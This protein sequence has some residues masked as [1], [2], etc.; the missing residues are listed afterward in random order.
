MV[1]TRSKSRSLAADLRLR[2]RLLRRSCAK[3]TE[4]AADQAHHTS[5]ST[6]TLVASSGAPTSAGS[7]SSSSGTATPASPQELVAVSDDDSDF[8]SESSDDSGSDESDFQEPPTR[9]YFVIDS[10]RPGADICSSAGTSI[11]FWQIQG[12]KEEDP[13]IDAPPEGDLDYFHRPELFLH[14]P[15][16]KSAWKSLPGPPEMQMV[17][18]PPNL[19]IRLLPFQREGFRGGVLADEM[20]M[21]KTLQTIGLMLVNRGKPTLVICPTVALMQWKSEI[22]A[23]YRRPKL[24]DENGDLNPSEL[25][26][27]DVVLTTYAVVE[28]SF[29]RER[30]GFRRHG[31]LLHED[32][33]LHK[34]HNIKDRSSNS[35]QQ[36]LQPVLTHYM[37]HFCYWNYHIMNPIQK[38]P[39]NSDKSRMAFTKLKQASTMDMGLP[40]RIIQT[41]RDKFSPEEED[42]YSTAQC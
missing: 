39:I 19:K 21:G 18:Q 26:K 37:S 20:G 27:Y 24:A 42:F 13:P 10:P 2:L 31:N 17:E 23:A 35:A 29:R 8:V 7:H 41:R 40:P 25:V 5:S 36:D 14:H 32:S 16:L 6:T 15:Q 28:S 22:E 4:A 3:N 11:S 33:V 38:N 30:Y 12:V 1:T 9:H 34:A